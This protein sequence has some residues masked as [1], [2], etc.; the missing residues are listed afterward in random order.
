M[1]MLKKIKRKIELSGICYLILTII[2][3][4]IS[5]TSLSAADNIKIKLPDGLYMYDSSISN[6]E[7]GS[8]WVGF[9][10]FFVVKNNTIY[11]SQ[12]AVKKFGVSKLNRLFTEKKKYKILFGG[13][14]IGEIYGVKI[15]ED[16][17]WN[18]QEELSIKNIK[19]GPVYR[20]ETIYIGRLGSAAK[21]I[22]VPEKYE[23]VRNISF[24]EIS[25]E[26]V[27]RISKLAV[28]RLFDLIKNRK[29]LKRF[30]I[31]DKKLDEQKIDLLDKISDFNGEMYIG[32]YRYIFRTAHEGVFE[33]QIL[34]SKK[35]DNIYVIT[36]DFD[37]EKNMVS[38]GDINICGMLDFDGC[39]EKELIVEKES[40]GPDEA[41]TILEIY[42]QKA[43]GN[44]IQIKKIKTRRV[45]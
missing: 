8:K 44:W 10:K 34:F 16:G 36:T 14:Q 5:T 11:S 13:K 40:G 18:Y 30:K 27:E 32:I 39:G 41:T 24:N 12:D 6:R 7:D 37:Y 29:E 42:K 2:A 4:L 38:E 33:L 15:D 17:N 43:D 35:K 9:E 23:V 45:L 28:D 1:K 19:Q 3:F 20:I 31:E 26:E 21:P 22:A 25:K